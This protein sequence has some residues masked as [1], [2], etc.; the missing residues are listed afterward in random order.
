MAA[1]FF[2]SCENIYITNRPV[3]VNRYTDISI[4]TDTE[5]T[6]SYSKLLQFFG[7]YGIEA[8]GLTGTFTYG[9]AEL[10]CM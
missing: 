2:A 4:L 8:V 9:H 5:S 7:F 1:Q 6:K 10:S 3:Y